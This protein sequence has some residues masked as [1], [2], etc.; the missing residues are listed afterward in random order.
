MFYLFS[1]DVIFLRNI[2]R[3]FFGRGLFLCSYRGIYNKFS[4]AVKDESDVF[5][6]DGRSDREKA[7]DA[8][9]YLHGRFPDCRCITFLCSLPYEKSRFRYLENSDFEVTDLMP[10]E[11]ADS[12]CA[13]LS[14]TGIFPQSSYRFL[15]VG[16]TEKRTKLLGFMLKVTPTEHR[17]LS[18]LCSRTGRF[19]SAEIILNCCFADSDRL[20][21]SCV[22]THISSVNRKAEPITNR[23]LIISEKDSGY[24]LSPYM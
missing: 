10:E 5:I 23:R 21:L 18:F 17:I 8:C 24:M 13:Y 6:I 11:A 4:P 3:V 19:T 16:D 1:G 14:H 20:T 2:K 9:R 7:D 22:S 15:N 12:I